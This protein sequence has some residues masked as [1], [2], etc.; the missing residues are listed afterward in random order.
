MKFLMALVVVEIHTLGLHELPLIILNGFIMSLE[1]ISV[2][3][4]F[5]FSSY[6]FFAKVRYMNFSSCIKH[7]VRFEKRLAILYFFWCIMNFVLVWKHKAYL[8]EIS[9]TTPILFIKDFLF[10]YIYPSSWFFGALMVSVLIIF[11]FS[12]VFPDYVIW[13][14]PLLIGIYCMYGKDLSSPYDVPYD[15]YYENIREPNLSCPRALFWVTLGHLASNPKVRNVYANL[16]NRETIIL[17]LMA[18]GMWSIEK[19]SAILMGVIALFTIAYKMKLPDRYQ[20]FYYKLR[21]F[22]TWFYCLHMLLIYMYNMVVLHFDIK[23]IS[24][25]FCCYIFV[26]LGLIIIANLLYSL[27]ASRYFSWLRYSY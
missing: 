17:L 19:Y 10:G 13:I 24:N 27:K 9:I 18:M 8:H 15:Y 1:D 16:K 11:V 23:L 4:F 22:S 5:V 3:L 25:H 14:I 26:L 21:V 2:P 20:Q 12:R 7:I 6:L